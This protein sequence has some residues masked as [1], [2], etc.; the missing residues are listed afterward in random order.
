MKWILKDKGFVVVLVV[1]V[2]AV[3]FFHLYRLDEIGRGLYVDES[4][5]GNYV[6]DVLRNIRNLQPDVMFNIYYMPLIFIFKFFGV[7]VFNLRFTSFIFFFISY[8]CVLWLVALLFKRNKTLIL[9]TG[10]SFGFLPQYFAV[11]RVTYTANAQLATIGLFLLTIYLALNSKKSGRG[12]FGISGVILG[13][14]I[15]TY[16]SSTLLT[17]FFFILTALL[18][19]KQ[20]IRPRIRIII[21]AGCF[22][23]AVA[24]FLYR[25]TA[26]TDSVV[27]TRFRRLTKLESTNVSGLGRVSDFTLNYL[28]VI[29]P[30]YLI[31]EG[32]PNLRHHAPYGGIIFKTVYVTFL[33]GVIFLLYGLRKKKIDRWLFFFLLSFFVSAVGG[34]LTYEPYHSLRGFLIGLYIVLISCFGLKEIYS[35]LNKH[36]LFTVGLFVFL[37]AEVV[38]YQYNYFTNFPQ[39]S[40][41]AFESAGFVESFDKA[42]EFGPEKVVLSEKTNLPHQHYKFYD[43]ITNIDRGLN[44]EIGALNAYPGSC[45]IYIPE[46]APKVEVRSTGFKYVDYTDPGWFYRVRCFYLQD[47]L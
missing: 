40:V 47:G 13:L 4:S 34:A 31:V 7:S 21:F 25:F 36:L 14:S 6:V 30:D 42:R 33:A 11:S 35:R 22:L 2:A 18:F 39:L 9:Y 27:N 17:P 26:R 28:R 38:H 41:M 24:P 19:F 15:Y 23:I 44:V 10:L 46:N 43:Q 5:V 37:T 20:L 1:I 16:T 32:D 8:L 29:S 12:L 3:C 45:L